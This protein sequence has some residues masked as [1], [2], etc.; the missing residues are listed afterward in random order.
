MQGSYGPA[1]AIAATGQFF[2]STFIARRMALISVIL[3]A[4]CF[5]QGGGSQSPARLSACLQRYHTAEPDPMPADGLASTFA[6]GVTYA[7]PCESLSSGGQMLWTVLVVARD[8][9]TV[10]AYF[11]GG[12]LQERCGLLRKVTVGEDDSN[13]VI[14]LESGGDPAFTEH[15]CPAVGERYVTQVTLEKP[16]GTRAISGPNN[17]GVVE[18][19]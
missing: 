8:G 16:L 17:D 18:H 10:R 13:V 4:A 15:A 1:E 14:S 6:T 7:V 2:L 3:L 11:M 19:L 12:R 9:V 5:G